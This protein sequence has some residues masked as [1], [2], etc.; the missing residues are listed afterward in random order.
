MSEKEKTEK[1]MKEEK[2]E[3]REFPDAEEVRA[4]LKAVSDFIANIKGPLKELIDTLMS[5][6]D[7]SKLGEE[8]ATLYKKLMNSGMPKE[9]VNEMVK[10]YFKH[11]LESAISPKAISEFFKGFM[12]PKHAHFTVSTEDLGRIMKTLEEIKKSKPEISGKIDEVITAIRKMAR[13]EKKE[14]E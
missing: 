6:L 13:T 12:K 4:I 10:T 5:S 14:E 1:E 9:M 3:E 7:G 2:E 8:V 11:K